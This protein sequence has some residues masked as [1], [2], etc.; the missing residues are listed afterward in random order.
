MEHN[1]KRRF[2]PYEAALHAD[3][4]SPQPTQYA[5]YGPSAPAPRRE[6]L[7]LPVP[8]SVLSRGGVT[9]G[10]PPALRSE[11]TRM[12]PPPLRNLSLS[13][14]NGPPSA[15]SHRVPQSAPLHQGSE[16]LRLPPLH[17]V[18]D[19]GRSLESLIMDIHF[20]GKIATLRQ[21]AHPIKGERSRHR[22]CIIAVEGDRETPINAVVGSLVEML[23]KTG[24][25]DVK[26][27]ECTASTSR[28]GGGEGLVRELH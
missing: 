10:R 12:P 20:L 17:S 22:G 6:S 11:S 2:N 26:V 16:S 24:E 8:T 5:A 9:I 21:V 23:R 1:K 27:M 18:D 3:T 13:N 7:P 25:F 15:T 28:R 14:H 4:G 19:G